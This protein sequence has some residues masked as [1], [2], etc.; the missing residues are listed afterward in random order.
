[1]SKA[2]VLVR[3]QLWVDAG[4]GLLPAGGRLYNGDPQSFPRECV[5]HADRTMAFV[6]DD[7]EL[8]KAA[9]KALEKYL[10]RPIKSSRKKKGEADE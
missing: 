6:F 3:H 10:N 4:A 2:K 8:A 7:A 1:M 5:N 9:A